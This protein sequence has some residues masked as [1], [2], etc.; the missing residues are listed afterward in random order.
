MAKRPVKI[1]K[2]YYEA[3]MYSFMNDISRKKVEKANT[4]RKYYDWFIVLKNGEPYREK[5]K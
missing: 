3:V 1:F 2:E 5:V 4:G